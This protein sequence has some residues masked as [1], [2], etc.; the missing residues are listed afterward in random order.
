MKKSVFITGGSRGIGR[1]TVYEFA[2][3]GCYI[4]FS[5]LNSDEEAQKIADEINSDM[6]NY[7]QAACIQYKSD[8][9]SLES[10]QNS[11]DNFVSRTGGLDCLVA[12]A[13]IDMYAQINDITKKDV[14]NIF[15]SNVFSV[16]Y[17]CKVASKYMIE[18]KSGSII[19]LSS[20]WGITGASCESLYSA[21]KGAVNAFTKSLA[22]ELGPSG[23]NVNS[24]APGVV[25]TDMMNGFTED[26]ISSLQNQSA[27]CKL[28]QSEDIA[29]IIYFLSTDSAS[30]ITG[31][32]ISPNCGILI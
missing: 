30:T 19:T 4:G 3:N 10:T 26:E 29:K 14:E 11:I 20:I 17:A 32:I 22:K 16:I 23:I 27:L 31:Q 28:C 12:N 2:K 21:T 9:R 8:V 5:Y 1:S 6:K 24:V 18:Q 13:G 7:P 25:M 15:S